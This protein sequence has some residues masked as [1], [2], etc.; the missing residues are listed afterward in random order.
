L[1]AGVHDLTWQP[2]EGIQESLEFH[3]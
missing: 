3:P 1:P 2:H